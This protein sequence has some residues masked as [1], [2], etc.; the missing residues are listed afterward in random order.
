MIEAF[1]PAAS[2]YAGDIDFLVNLIFW[3]VGFWFVLS[4]LVFFYLIFRFRKRDGE[5]GQYVSGEEKSQ[6]RWITIPH[7][8]VLVCDLVI[9]VPA[10]KVWYDIK[11]DL[12]ARPRPRFGSSASSGRGPLS[13]PVR[14]PSWIPRMTSP[15]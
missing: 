8:L 3:I 7:I 12:P 6:K 2:T 14:T 11:Q 4:E 5:P 1:V 10:I 15:R 9:L 13:T